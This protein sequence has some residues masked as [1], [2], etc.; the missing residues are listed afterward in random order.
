MIDMV[1]MCHMI[2]LYDK[3]QNGTKH[4]KYASKFVPCVCI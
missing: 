4:T 2:V 3:S 1:G